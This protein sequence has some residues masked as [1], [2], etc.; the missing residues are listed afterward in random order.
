LARDPTPYLGSE[1]GHVGVIFQGPLVRGARVL[2]QPQMRIRYGRALWSSRAFEVWM[3]KWP[4]LI[5]GLSGISDQAKKAVCPKEPWKR[6]VALAA[7]KARGCYTLADY[8]QW[9]KPLDIG[10][11]TRLRLF[12]IAAFPDT[13]YNILMRMLLRFAI[14][15][16][17]ATLLELR[18]SRFDYR[19]RWFGIAT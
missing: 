5:W 13:L 11:L 18:Q 8:R 14:P 6:T 19:R 17:K 10:P 15:R 1:F 7:M 4:R 2:A 12:A 9:I 16:A 3:F